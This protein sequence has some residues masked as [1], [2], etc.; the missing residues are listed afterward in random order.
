MKCV[1]YANLDC[2]MTWRTGR[3]DWNRSKCPE[4]CEFL[5]GQTSL[6]GALVKPSAAKSRPGTSK[7]R[8]SCTEQP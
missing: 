6:T 3:G 8:Q 1:I 5:K 4:T 2:H 7:P